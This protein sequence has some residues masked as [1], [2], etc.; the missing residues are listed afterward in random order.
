MGSFHLFSIETH[1]TCY[2][3]LDEDKSR[4]VSS[5][6]GRRYGESPPGSS[7]VRWPLRFSFT[8]PSPPCPLDS[9]PLKGRGCVPLTVVP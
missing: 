9:K 7:G 8:C 4:R 3:D 6:L 2:Y 5:N 1:E